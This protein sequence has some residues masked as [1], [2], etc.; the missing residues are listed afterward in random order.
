MADQR[1]SE[2]RVH[3][4]VSA[5]AAIMAIDGTWR[6]NCFIEDVSQTGAKISVPDSV[7]G[8]SLREFFLVLGM[9]GTAYRR[10][11]MVWLNGGLM[12]VRFRP[13]PKGEYVDQRKKVQAQSG[14]KS[15]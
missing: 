6:R 12:G 7:Q 3:F 14:L 15:D 1:R 5:P 13:K 11:E 8:L 9:R 4:E 2:K 10:C